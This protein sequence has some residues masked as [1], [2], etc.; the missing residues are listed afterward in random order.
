MT[1]STMYTSW[2]HWLQEL[3]LWFQIT[4]PSSY[5][6]RLC[7]HNGIR[8]IWREKG[9]E[10]WSCVV[11]LGRQRIDTLWVV[12]DKESW[13]PILYSVQGFKARALAR[14]HQDCL[15]FTTPGMFRHEMG[16]I[17]VRHKP[18]CVY[19][20]WIKSPRPSSPHLDTASDQI[21]E[22]GWPGNK[23]LKVLLQNKNMFEY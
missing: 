3:D 5:S 15:S 7:Q 22:M 21:L 11:T 12:A 8:Q 6:C 10:N 20:H 18:P 19:L 17:T 1:A 9:R 4:D 14:Q 23:D 13:S 16:I 2:E